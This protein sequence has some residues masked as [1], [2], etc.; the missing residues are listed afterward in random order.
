[1]CGSEEMIA[2]VDWMGVGLCIYVICALAIASLVIYK[3]R[4]M[5]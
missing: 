1:M 4:D 5:F 2:T 3:S